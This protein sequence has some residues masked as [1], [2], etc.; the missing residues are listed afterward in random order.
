MDELDRLKEAIVMSWRVPFGQTILWDSDITNRLI[1][2]WPGQI[3]HLLNENWQKEKEIQNQKGQ[4][5]KLG[6][7]DSLAQTI[8]YHYY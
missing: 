8:Y 2:S 4:K 3:D 5:A 6:K 1:Q 7:S